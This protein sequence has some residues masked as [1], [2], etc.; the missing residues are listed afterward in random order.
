MDEFVYPNPFA[1][2]GGGGGRG[3]Y[4]TPEDVGV[5]MQSAP[6]IPTYV[7]P[8]INPGWRLAPP[9]ED[10]FITFPDGTRAQRMIAR[11]ERYNDP[12]LSGLGS[13]ERQFYGQSPYAY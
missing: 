1:R 9:R 11:F 2:R 10:D 5:P 8:T 4:V 3:F 13:W 7:N 12:K 6:A